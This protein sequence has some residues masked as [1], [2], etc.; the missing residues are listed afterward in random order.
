MMNWSSILTGTTDGKTETKYTDEYVN[1]LVE[2]VEQLK[3]E[4]ETLSIKQAKLEALNKSHKS[5]KAEDE[6]IIA[7]LQSQIQ[8]LQEKLTHTKAN[9]SEIRELT[10]RLE[11]SSAERQKKLEASATEHAKQVE[12][13]Y[14]ERLKVIEGKIKEAERNGETQIAEL[15]SALNAANAKLAYREEEFL[16]SISHLKSR[17]AQAEN[18]NFEL[19]GNV[20]ASTLPFTR[21]IETLQNQLMIKEDRIRELEDG[22]EILLQSE[23]EKTSQAI[24][25]LKPLQAE[26]LELKSK[27]R[28]LEL[29]LDEEKRVA[30]QWKSKCEN[31][32]SEK[33]KLKESILKLNQDHVTA[34]RGSDAK[35]AEISGKCQTLESSLQLEKEKNSQLE[36]KLKNCEDEIRMERERSAAPSPMGPSMPSQVTSSPDVKVTSVAPSG[37][38]QMVASPVRKFPDKYLEHSNSLGSMPAI[39][40]MDAMRSALKRKDGEIQSLQDSITQLL[41]HRDRL[42]DELVTFTLKTE[43]MEKEMEEFKKSNGDVEL[44]KKYDALLLLFGEREEQVDEMKEDIREMKEAYRSQLQELIDKLEASQR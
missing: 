11:D 8:D 12:K 2:Q 23:K 9:E 4:G 33:F 20:S 35:I 6:K 1:G 10:R 43:S 30:N 27:V 17:L 24:N 41:Q 7:S 16:S 14:E 40:G 15:R 29:D 18:A 26:I 39:G 19:S 31:S 42:Q 5:A 21:Q 28:R 32:E 38:S 22:N 34:L 36:I 37:S 25:S 13:E 3:K 44:K